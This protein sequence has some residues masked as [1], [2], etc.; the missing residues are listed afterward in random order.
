[1]SL[2]RDNVEPTC[3]GSGGHL[4][5]ASPVTRVTPYSP[6][7]EWQVSELLPFSLHEPVLDQHPDQLAGRAIV[8]RS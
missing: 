8:V 3:E 6:S 2:R 5:T 1:M 4:T 7:G